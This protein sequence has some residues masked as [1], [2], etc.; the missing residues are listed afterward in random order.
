MNKKKIGIN[1]TVEKVQE[2]VRLQAGNDL[3]CMNYHSISLGQALVAPQKISAIARNVV[4]GHV[5]DEIVDVWLIGEEKPNDGYRIVMR[6]DGTQFGLASGGFPAD[7]HLVLI[8]WYGSL[9]A[10]F[11]GM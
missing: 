9:K 1:M 3:S 8:G 7:K 5:T 2:I 11:L 6:E 10:T 4:N